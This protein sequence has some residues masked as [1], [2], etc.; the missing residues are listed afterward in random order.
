MAEKETVR[1]TLER[2]E[3]LTMLE[4][5]NKIQ[6]AKIEELLQIIRDLKDEMS[7]RQ[8]RKKLIVTQRD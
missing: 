1:I 6:E 3:Q 8:R 7:G 2:F 5:R 4:N